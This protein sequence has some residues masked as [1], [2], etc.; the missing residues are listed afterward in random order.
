MRIEGGWVGLEEF[1]FSSLGWGFG[2]EDLLFNKPPFSKMSEIT[3]SGVRH[4]INMKK[5]DDGHNFL[6]ASLSVWEASQHS[7]IYNLT[8]IS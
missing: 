7:N 1:F 2:R 5:A 3:T 4:I 8:C 6:L